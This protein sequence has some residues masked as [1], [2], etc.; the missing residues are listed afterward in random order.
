MYRSA[1]VT[2]HYRN[3]NPHP[4]LF[5]LPLPVLSCPRKI[6]WANR[7][8]PVSSRQ[9][10]HSRRNRCASW[11]RPSQTQATSCSTTLSVFSPVP[12]AT[13]GIDAAEFK[14]VQYTN[15]CNRW[16]SFWIAPF[17]IFR[18]YRTFLLLHT[19][20]Q[21][22]CSTSILLRCSLRSA[23]TEEHEQVLSLRCL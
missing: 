1:M 12:D 6:G 10:R 8:I 5:T 11:S 14:T 7:S 3:N 23:L 18:G 2:S 22:A 20:P 16:V 4:H 9:T 15:C 21:M 13:L 19:K 17:T